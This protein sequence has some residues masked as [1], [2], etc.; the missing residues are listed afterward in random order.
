MS[1][2]R[3]FFLKTGTFCDSCDLFAIL[4][5]HV[6]SPKK[7]TPFRLSVVAHVY[8]LQTWVAPGLSIFTIIIIREKIFDDDIYITYTVNFKTI[9]GRHF[10]QYFLKWKFSIFSGSNPLPPLVFWSLLYPWVRGYLF[11]CLFVCWAVFC[12]F[13]CL[14]VFSS[15]CP[16]RMSNRFSMMA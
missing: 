10:S 12:L 13:V 15:K 4:V 6:H 16:K 5:I 1:E 3:P 9:K 11:V 2:T 14:F 8:I 7:T